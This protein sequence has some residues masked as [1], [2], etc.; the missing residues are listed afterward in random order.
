MEH[1]RLRKHFR[2][3]KGFMPPE[4]AKMCSKSVPWLGEE[5]HMGN[6]LSAKSEFLLT[7]SLAQ[8]F[9]VPT[10]LLPYDPTLKLIAR[11]LSKYPS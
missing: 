8:L 7:R 2:N 10:S 1:P 9:L 3:Q 6:E 4:V 5:S 11:I